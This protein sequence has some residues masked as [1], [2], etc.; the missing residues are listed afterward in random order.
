M[1]D[2]VTT[3]VVSSTAVV[4]VITDVTGTAV[5]PTIVVTAAATTFVVAAVAGKVNDVVIAIAVVV[6]L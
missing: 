2:V 6:W 5:S 1:L 3:F 4:L